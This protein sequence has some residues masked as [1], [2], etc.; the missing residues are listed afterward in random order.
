MED[1]R[2]YIYERSAVLEHI[3]VCKTRN[4]NNPSQV[5]HPAA[6]VNSWLS[7]AELKP[8]RRVLNERRRRQLLA[9]TG[10]TQGMQAG[11]SAQAQRDEV[12]LDA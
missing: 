4:R 5:Q 8:C 11:S 2:G 6:G 9:V 1:S 12:V 3:R 10:A 7:A